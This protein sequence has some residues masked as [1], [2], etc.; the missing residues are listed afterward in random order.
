MCADRVGDSTQHLAI[1]AKN[2]QSMEVLSTP[3]DSVI[4][5]LTKKAILD[6]KQFWGELQ[7]R[8]KDR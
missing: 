7:G 2:L 8:C 6:C 1:V 3:Y 5:M 4:T